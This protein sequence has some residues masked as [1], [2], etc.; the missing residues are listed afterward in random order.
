VTIT[1]RTF[2]KF[3]VSFLTNNGIRWL[4]GGTGLQ[5][6]Y[7]VATSTMRVP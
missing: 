7:V 3:Y 2:K 1:T 4:G 5:G 6:T